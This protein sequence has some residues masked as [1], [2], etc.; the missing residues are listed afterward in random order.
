MMSALLMLGCK[1]K[2][3]AGSEQ[4]TDPAPTISCNLSEK[5]VGVEGEVFSISLTTK[6]EWEITTQDDWVSASPTQGAGNATI[7]ITVLPGYD[8]ETNILIWTTEDYIQLHI[9]RKDNVEAQLP[10]S[11]NGAL[12]GKFTIS[13]NQQV[14]FS[15]GNLQYRASK[16]E[17]RFATYQFNVIGEGNRNISPSYDGWIDLFGWGTSGYANKFP[18]MTSENPQQYGGGTKSITGTEYDWGVHNSISNGGNQKGL[19]RT[20][21]YDEWRYVVFYRPSAMDLRSIATVCG[22]KGI[23]LLPD[24]FEMPEGIEWVPL[25]DSWTTNTYTN[26]SWNKLQAAGAVFLPGGGMRNGTQLGIGAVRFWTSTSAG[27]NEAAANINADSEGKIRTNLEQ[28]YWG[29][30]VRLVKNVE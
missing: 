2:T 1:T 22:V 29:Y 28:R 18:Y 13:E 6:M 15:Q 11:L 5:T 17:W 7:E 19:W 9:I 27:D 24:N 30:S 16:D 14:Y 4:P 21:N 20:L 12:P 23:M 10:P 26:N 3:P 8:A 25:A